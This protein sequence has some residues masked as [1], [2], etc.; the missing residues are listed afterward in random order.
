M[1]PGG[2]SLNLTSENA[3]MFFFCERQQL[4]QSTLQA[5]VLYLTVTAYFAYSYSIYVVLLLMY[6]FQR[7]SIFFSF[8]T[9][10]KLHTFVYCIIFLGIGPLRSLSRPSYFPFSWERD[11]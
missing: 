11:T 8:I 1:F 2:L 4:V 10:F 6:H 5:L 3:G 7:Y 9:Y